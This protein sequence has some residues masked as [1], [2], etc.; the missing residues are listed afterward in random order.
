M[1]NVCMLWQAPEVIV[2]ESNQPHLVRTPTCLYV[3]L[4][5]C[6]ILQLQIHDTLQT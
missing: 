6:G 3:I 1:R 5:C 2:P 4:V